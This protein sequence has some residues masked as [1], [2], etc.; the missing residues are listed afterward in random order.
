MSNIEKTEQER[1][2]ILETENASLKADVAHLSG[3]VQYLL[4][5]VRLGRKREFGTSSEKS[6]YDPEQVNLFNEAEVFAEPIAAEPEL[7]E[8]EKHYRKKRR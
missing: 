4:E 3:Q 1:I 6:E 2:A 5:Q 8:V 7:C